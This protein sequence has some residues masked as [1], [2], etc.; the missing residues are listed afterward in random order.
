MGRMFDRKSTFFRQKPMESSFIK[1]ENSH[2][3]RL[4]CRRH[5]IRKVVR[6]GRH[7]N[8]RTANFA[9]PPP[10]IRRI[11]WINAWYRKFIDDHDPLALTVT[12]N[13]LS[14]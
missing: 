12:E 7:E 3:R 10:Q 11:R 4:T 8:F 9:N 1:Q 14:G 2:R 13:S 6:Y 5:S